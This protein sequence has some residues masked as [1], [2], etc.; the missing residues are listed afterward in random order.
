MSHHRSIVDWIVKNKWMLVDIFGSK[1]FEKIAYKNNPENSKKILKAIYWKNDIDTL[2]EGVPDKDEI[3]ATLNRLFR[4]FNQ[5][6]EEEEKSFL[7]WK[8]NDN[9]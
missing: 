1:L 2:F 8:S 5:Q 4:Y 6:K 9:E 3:K 7:F